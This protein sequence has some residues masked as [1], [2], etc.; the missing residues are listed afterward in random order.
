MVNFLKPVSQ[1]EDF[2]VVPNQFDSGANFLIIRPKNPQLQNC[3]IEILSAE[4]R[5]VFRATPSFSFSK[6][7]YSPDL[8]SLAQGLYFLRIKANDKNYTFKLVKN[9]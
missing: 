7:T 4:G 9:L 1:Q 6:D 2:E 8:S 3:V 5:E